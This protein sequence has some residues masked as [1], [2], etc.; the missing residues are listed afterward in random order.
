MLAWELQAALKDGVHW[1]DLLLFHILHQIHFL[2][3]LPMMELFWEIVFF[4]SMAVQYRSEIT[5]TFIFDVNNGPIT[6][7]Q[8]MFKLKTLLKTAGWTVPSSSDGLTVFPS[9][10]GI[11]GNGSGAGQIGNSLSWFRIK[12]PTAVGLYQRELLIQRSS[13][14]GTGWMVRYSLT[15]FTGGSPTATVPPSAADQQPWLIG[16]D[17]P[18]ALYDTDNTYRFNAGADNAPPYGFWSCCYALTSPS[19]FASGG[20]LVMDP[21]KAGSYPPEDQDPYIMLFDNPSSGTFNY[22]KL[23]SI[24]VCY[25]GLTADPPFGTNWGSC[26]AARMSVSVGVNGFIFPQG[27]G[28]DPYSGKDQE[29]EIMWCFPGQSNNTGYY[30]SYG[31]LKGIGTILRW[32]GVQRDSGTTHSIATGTSK[33]RLVIADVNVPW[34]GTDSLPSGGINVGAELVSYPNF[35]PAA[36]AGNII[37]E[38]QAIDN[39]TGDLYRWIFTGASPDFAGTQYPGPNSPTNI[40]IASRPNA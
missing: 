25:Y 3:K 28:A 13:F 8:A 29:C 19:H 30:T 20:G 35:S 4:H 15:G 1:Q 11:V 10:D 31:G 2:S 34:N 36:P 22:N 17:F 5:M 23:G 12:Q 33:E 16:L 26:N 7:D 6:G 24:P 38:M 9:S 14:G 21:M 40:S 32:T 18:T 27:L 39:I 37:Y